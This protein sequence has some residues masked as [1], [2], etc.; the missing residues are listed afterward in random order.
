MSAE[1][2][3]GGAVGNQGGK[4]KTAPRW[5]TEHG[6]EVGIYAVFPHSRHLSAKV[7]AFVDFFVERFGGAPT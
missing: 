1:M 5:E 3:S 2:G 7:R 4:N 6:D